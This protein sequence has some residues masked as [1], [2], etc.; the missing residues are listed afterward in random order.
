MARV[1]CMFLMAVA[2]L[3]AIPPAARAQLG[4]EAPIELPAELTKPNLSHAVTVD[5][6]LD[7]GPDWTYEPDEPQGEVQPL[8]KPVSFSLP[9]STDAIAFSTARAAIAGVLQD[10]TETG[11][12]KSIQRWNLYRYK[13]TTGQ[14]SGPLKVYA[15]TFES[16]TPGKVGNDRERLSIRAGALLTVGPD[17]KL[18]VVRTN[19]AGRLDVWSLADGGRHLVAWQPYGHESEFNRH[20][21]WAAGLDDG[22]VL[23]LNHQGRLIRWKLP[24]CI[25]LYRR[26]LG[27]MSSFSSLPNLGVGLQPGL[28]VNHQHIAIWSGKALLII[29]AI[30]GKTLA[31]LGGTEDPGW[32]RPTFHWDGTKLACTIAQDYVQ[33]LVIYDLRT[34]AEVTRMPLPADAW[35]TPSTS[36][37]RQGGFTWVGEPFGVVGS[38]L[39]INLVERRP[40]WKFNEPPPPLHAMPVVSTAGPD[41][42]A[43]TTAKSTQSLSSFQ[44]PHADA[45]QV[46]KEGPELFAAGPGSEISLEVKADASEEVKSALEKAAMLRVQDVAMKLAKDARVKLLVEAEVRDVE[47]PGLVEGMRRSLERAGIKDKVKIQV[48]TLRTSYLVDGKVAWSNSSDILPFGADVKEPKKSVPQQLLDGQWQRVRDWARNLLQG[49]PGYVQDPAV[50]A[51]LP[52]GPY[53]SEGTISDA[54]SNP[55]R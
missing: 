49:I 22:T 5:D 39:L 4:T 50:L 18:A 11:G 6:A 19:D 15:R 53:P 29:D 28:S 46:A 12:G 40:V 55:P 47:E 26:E 34:G 23:T 2:S 27:R 37:S 42:W 41:F 43:L 31:V 48:V 13:L 35:P 52:S 32:L 36:N 54:R 24:E 16:R 3:L 38:A 17:G 25:A 14:Q 45:L 8:A 10:V 7:I 30:T 44:L 1:A 9:Y 33:I 51:A 21:S 20:V